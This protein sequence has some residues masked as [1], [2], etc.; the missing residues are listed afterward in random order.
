MRPLDDEEETSVI[1][2]ADM[3]HRP[4]ESNEV[5]VDKMP[6]DSGQNPSAAPTSR[7]EG[8]ASNVAEKRK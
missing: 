7:E 6:Q 8:E 1:A 4:V 5:E 2:D 3:A